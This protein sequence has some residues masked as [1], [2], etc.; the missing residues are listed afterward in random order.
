MYISDI[1]V[2]LQMYFAN[3]DWFIWSGTF[4]P[5]D[6]YKITYKIMQTDKL[7]TAQLK[8]LYY[9]KLQVYGVL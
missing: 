9:S 3:A 5:Q 2:I 8:P 1:S 7:M 4:S 6:F